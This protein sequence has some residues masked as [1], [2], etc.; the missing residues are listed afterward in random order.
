MK[1]LSAIIFLLK[2]YFQNY[3]KVKLE[4]HLLTFIFRR[5]CTKVSDHQRML[6]MGNESTNEQNE[7]T[8]KKKQKIQ[9]S[10]A[11]DPHENIYKKRGIFAC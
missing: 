10:K 6:K 7:E 3:V 1:R 8:N 9:S 2:V 4:F 11:E 5:K